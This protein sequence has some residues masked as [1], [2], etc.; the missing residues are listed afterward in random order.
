VCFWEK[1]KWGFVLDP[2]NEWK[3]IQPFLQEQ[4]IELK[5]ILL[6]KPT[7]KNAF[8]VAQIKQETGAKFLSFKSDLLQ[9]RNLPKLADEVNVCGIKVPHVDHFLDGLEQF[10]LS[11]KMLI[12]KGSEGIHQYAIESHVFPLES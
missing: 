2:A 11:G 5:Y 6:S 1:P 3:H 8:R 7:F 9:L 4:Q 12:I 10:D